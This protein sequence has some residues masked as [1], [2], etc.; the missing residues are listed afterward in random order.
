[1]NRIAVYVYNDIEGEIKEYARFAVKALLN[2]ADKLIVVINGKM[3]PLEV[4]KLQ[5]PKVTV[6]ERENTGFDFHAYRE[7]FLSLTDAELCS[8]DELVFTNNSVFGPIFPYTEI[9]GTMKSREVDFWGITKHPAINKRVKFFD[10]STKIKEH[11]Q[12]Y[13]IVFRH[14]MI[15]D[16]KFR[17]YFAKMPKLE[18]KKDAIGKIEVNLTEHFKKLGFTYDTFVDDSVFEY[19]VPNAMQYLPDIMIEKY[20]VPFI[21]KTAF[22]SRYDLAQRETLGGRTK[23][24]FDY[25]KTKTNYDI[26]LITQEII[27]NYPY[28]NILKFLKLDFPLS[29]TQRQNFSPDKSA[30]F[31]D[32]SNL[33]INKMIEPYLE[34]LYG[35][36][37]I[38][39][40]N[41]ENYDFKVTGAKLRFLDNHKNYYEQ[42]QALSKTYKY[43]CFI[44]PDSKAISKMSFIQKTDYVNHFLSCTIASKFYISNVIETFKNNSFLGVL[45]P[46]PYIL[47]GF[48][49]YKTKILNKDKKNFVKT[50]GYYINASNSLISSILPAFWIS[51]HAF[52]KI[53][54]KIDFENADSINKGALFSM[55]SLKYG[56][57]FGRISTLDAMQ[58]YLSGLEYKL[59]NQTKFLSKLSFKLGNKKLNR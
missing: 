42:I 31:Y 54:A 59:V 26:S 55:L 52:N 58:N 44:I 2:I 32:C 41:K 28:D 7:A 20:S 5:S 50:H 37:D 8:C 3:K 11:I 15:I 33:E 9:F 51:S 19:N 14:N 53:N 56:E 47:S 17:D 48:E 39:I 10:F 24:A 1:M 22:G 34:R 18:T 49:P 40:I 27:Q 45:T 43:M 38:Y 21:K 35:L 12:T 30:I 25:I 6:I 36:I 16:K 23:R 13:F 57:L 46:I 29:D 4:E